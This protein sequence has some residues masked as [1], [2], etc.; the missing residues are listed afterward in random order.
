MIQLTLWATSCANNLYSR[1]ECSQVLE[2]A[3]PHYEIVSTL[4][5]TILAWVGSTLLDIVQTQ[6]GH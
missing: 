3:H 6:F 5:G 4:P 1:S 2:L